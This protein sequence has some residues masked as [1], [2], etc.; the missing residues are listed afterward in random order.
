MNK[1]AITHLQTALDGY[2]NNLAG[3]SEYVEK[4]K[5]NLAKATTHKQEMLDMIDEL[6]TLLG[7]DAQ[8]TAETEAPEKMV[9]A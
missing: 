1:K 4:A 6:E 8:P 3:V 9:E 2:R 5:E 7:D